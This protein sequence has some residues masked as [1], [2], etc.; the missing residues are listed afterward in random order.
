[1]IGD[2]QSMKHEQYGVKNNFNGPMMTVNWGWTE[3]CGES[4]SPAAESAL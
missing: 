4:R 3:E 2:T 1:L